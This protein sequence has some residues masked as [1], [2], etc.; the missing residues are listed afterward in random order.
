MKNILITVVAMIVI[1]LVQML[2]SFTFTYRVGEIFSGVAFGILFYYSI[3]HIG[4]WKA[5]RK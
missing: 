5:I 4:K 3:I 2:L 1:I